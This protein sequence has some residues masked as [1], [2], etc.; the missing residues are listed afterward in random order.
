[1][2]IGYSLVTSEIVAADHADYGDCAKYQI[3]CPRCREAVFKGKRTHKQQETHY[4]SHYHATS[5]EAR[6]CEMRVERL[7]HKYFAAVAIDGHGQTLGQFMAVLKE[8]VVQG[9][10]EMG[11]VPYATLWRDANRIVARS[12]FDFFEQP[13]RKLAGVGSAAYRGNTPEF[14]AR[15]NLA[16]ELGKMRPFANRSQ[17]WLRRQASYVL[18]VLT[19]IVTPQAVGN[20]RFVAACSYSLLRS[21]PG[22]YPPPDGTDQDE[23]SLK[24]SRALCEGWSPR[25]VED[26]LEVRWS[27]KTHS[28]PVAGSQQF[29]VDNELQRLLM[30]AGATPMGRSALLS[31][32]GGRVGI[33]ISEV[34]TVITRVAISAKRDELVVEEAGLTRTI[35]DELAKAAILTLTIDLWA[36]FLGLLAGVPPRL[37]ENQA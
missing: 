34:P 30:G 21:V 12:D 1:M 22:V 17:F 25:K 5:D 28:R 7:A 23:Y 13:L 18:D 6:E 8:N 14:N 16:I 32:T 20:F 4:F 27:S 29:D 35:R 37:L 10:A 33:K 24:V 15:E 19:H 11:V 9:Q 2:R 26:L 3:T 36:P 31:S